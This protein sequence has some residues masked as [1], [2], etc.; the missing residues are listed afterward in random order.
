MIVP[1]LCGMSEA[2]LAVSAQSGAPDRAMV[3]MGPQPGTI[4]PGLR[5]KSR[6]IA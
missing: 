4:V 1:A 6:L 3:V 5:V 2:M